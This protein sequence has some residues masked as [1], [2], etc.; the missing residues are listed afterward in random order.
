MRVASTKHFPNAEDVPDSAPKLEQGAEKKIALGPC[1][2]ETYGSLVLGAS[3][4]EI[5]IDEE[6]SLR[7]TSQ[8]S[9]GLLLDRSQVNNAS[10]QVKQFEYVTPDSET[11]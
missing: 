8:E 4:D 2:Y 3:K 5:C 1:E 7:K 10:K 6:L 9:L 11:S